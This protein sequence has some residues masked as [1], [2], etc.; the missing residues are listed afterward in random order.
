MKKLMTAIAHIGIAII[1]FALIVFI[2]IL[3]VVH[4]WTLWGKVLWIAAKA[5]LAVS[6]LWAGVSLST[7]LSLQR[8][9][10]EEKRDGM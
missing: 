5:L 3:E 7:Y 8:K 1:T 2:I 4:D 10:R 6:V 9:E